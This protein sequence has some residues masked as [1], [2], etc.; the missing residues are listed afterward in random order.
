MVWQIVAG[1]ILAVTFGPAI[2]AFLAP[3]VLRLPAFCIVVGGLQVAVGVLLYLMIYAGGMNWPW[4][5]LI[6]ALGVYY[7]YRGT[8]MRRLPP[9]VPD[10]GTPKVEAK[11]MVAGESESPVD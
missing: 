7:I 3:A 10:A 1:F 4:P 6:A 5:L 9:E 2:L 11:T 8:E